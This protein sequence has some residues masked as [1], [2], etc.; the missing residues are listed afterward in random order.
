[1]S[2]HFY[3]YLISMYGSG[4][5][6]NCVI[7]S[8]LIRGNWLYHSRVAECTISAS[9]DNISPSEPRG[10]YIGSQMINRSRDPCYLE[11]YS[12][13]LAQDPVCIAQWRQIVTMQNTEAFRQLVITIMQYLR[14]IFTPVPIGKTI[15]SLVAYL[16]IYC[17]ASRNW[18]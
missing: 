9:E 17:K 18:R 7:A 12:H 11:N 10:W 5:Q 1:M 6:I 13:S 2:F 3:I 15:K 4:W 16:A 8:L 14:S